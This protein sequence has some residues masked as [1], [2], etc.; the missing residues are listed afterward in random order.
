MRVRQEG[1]NNGGRV[2]GVE[3]MEE[4]EGRED[5][6]NGRKEKE[7]KALSLSQVKD[8]I[9]MG[10]QSQQPPYPPLHFPYGLAPP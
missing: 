5:K 10:V 7:G 4:E 1:E 8:L 9:N 6:S 2:R 3:E